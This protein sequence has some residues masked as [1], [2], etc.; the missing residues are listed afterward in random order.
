MDY[1][2]S[3]IEQQLDMPNHRRGP[4]SQ[5]EDT[6]LMSLVAQSG[7]NNWGVNADAHLTVVVAHKG[8]VAKSFALTSVNET[9][10]KPVLDELKKALGK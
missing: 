9:D 6:Y 8:K 3:F 2:N 5:A 7:P 1:S 10:V 4:W